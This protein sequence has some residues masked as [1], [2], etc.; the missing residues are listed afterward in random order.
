MGPVDNVELSCFR[1]RGAGGLPP[2]NSDVGGRHLALHVE[3][4]DAAA[5]YLGAL[6]GFTVLG[7][8]ETITDGPIAG[9]RWVYVRSPLGLHIELVNMPDGSLPYERET[10]A[11]RRAAGELRWSDQ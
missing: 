5:T 8:P 1:G 3:D 11:R 9:D 7:A 10:T 6:P 2:R 4:V